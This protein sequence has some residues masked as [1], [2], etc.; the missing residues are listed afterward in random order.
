VVPVQF[1][2]VA[3]EVPLG[4]RHGDSSNWA[5]LHGPGGCA[6]R[7]QLVFLC[8]YGGLNPQS[9]CN[10]KSPTLK[11]INRVI[12]RGNAFAR[13]DLQRRNRNAEGVRVV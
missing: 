8:S 10:P 1:L 3:Q 7:C 6:R 9:S 5:V 4:S 11:C 13:T 2:A 12:F